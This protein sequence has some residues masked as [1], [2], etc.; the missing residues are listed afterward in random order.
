MCGAW[1]GILNKN[2]WVLDDWTHW[3][4]KNHRQNYN[5]EVCDPTKGWLNRRRREEGK[6]LE[7]KNTKWNDYDSLP[8]R[9]LSLSQ[10][11]TQTHLIS[12]AV[13]LAHLLEHTNTYTNTQ[14]HIC[15]RT[16]T[17]TRT[18]PKQILISGGCWYQ[19][20]YGLRSAGDL[21]NLYR[22]YFTKLDL[23]FWTLM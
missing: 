2:S 5:T 7:L 4:K 10:S 9:S 18:Y 11:H 8:P 21:I 6:N 13:I 20:I 17:Q 15:N 14:R 19:Q 22:W 12:H 3:I 1:R 16:S 23:Y